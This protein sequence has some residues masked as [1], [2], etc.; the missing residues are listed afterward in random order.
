MV[1]MSVDLTSMLCHICSFQ[2]ES[3]SHVFLICDMAKEIWNKVVKCFDLHFPLFLNVFEILS[4]IDCTTLSHT[5]RRVIEVIIIITILI[6][7]SYKNSVMFQTHSM[8]KS[9]IFESIAF[10]FLIGF[11]I[12]VV[13]VISLGLVVIKSST[14]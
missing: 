8:R 3:C 4:W 12:D 2:I 7:W 9:H 14:L 1:N 13:K 5:K 6:I 11:R 10:I